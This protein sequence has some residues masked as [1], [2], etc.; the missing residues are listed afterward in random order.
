MSERDTLDD[1]QYRDKYVAFLD[2][3][4]FSSLT[5]KADQHPS[6][7]AWLRDCINNLNQ[8]LPADNTASGFRFVQFSDSVVLSVDRTPQGLI[9]ILQSVKLLYCNMLNRQVLLRGGVAAGNFHHDDRL[10]FG[11]ALI[12]A[13]NFEKSGAPP[14]V[15]LDPAVLEDLK[16]SLI[17]PDLNYLITYDPWDMSPMLDVLLDF[18]LY[19]AVPRPGSVFLDKS[20][21]WLAHRIEMN[22]SDMASPPSARS[23]WRWLQHY[24]NQAVSAQNILQ[25][26]SPLRDWDADWKALQ[27]RLGHV[28]AQ[29]NAMI[30]EAG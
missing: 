5:E 6:W 9:T 28:E 18:R 16:P 20:A 11:P 10:M 26:S 17:G 12:R 19:D 8:S 25:E 27:T 30:D 22:A 7:R 13:Y 23:K 4:G 29:Q 15:G 2:I 1:S 24:W 21:F 3:L 14:H